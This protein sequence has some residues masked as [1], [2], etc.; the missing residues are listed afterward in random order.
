M[1]AGQLGVTADQV[2]QAVEWPPRPQAASYSPTQWRDPKLVLGDQVQVQ[3][4][5]AQMTSMKDIETI[6]VSSV[7]GADPLVSEVA[8][9]RNGSVRGNSTARTGF[10]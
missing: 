5:Q 3:V 9:V 1:L 2:G 4:P 10:G 6:P 7:T 8:S